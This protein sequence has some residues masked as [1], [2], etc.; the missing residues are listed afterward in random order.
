MA[1][2]VYL[3]NEGSKEDRDLLG[4]KGA[5]LCEMTNLGLP[6]P[7]GFIITTSTCREFFQAGNRLPNLLEQEYRVAL[8]LIEKKMGTRFGDPDNPLLFSVRSGAP[9]SMPG[10][11][12]TILNL[13]MN[14]EITEGLARKTSNPRFA[15]DSYRRFI[16]MFADVVLDIDGRLFEGEITRYKDAHSKPLDTDMTAEDWQAVIETFKSMA[17]FPQDPFEQ[18]KL[19]VQ[20]VFLSW[21][22][23]RAIVYREMNNIP[24]SLGTAVNVQA[25]VFGNYGEDSGSGVAFTRNPSTGENEFFGE[26]LF[27]AAGEDVVA[28]VRTPEPVEALRKRLTGV[29]DELYETQDLLEKHYRDMQDIEFTVQ[30]GRFYMLQTRSGKRTGRASIKIA[31]DMVDEQLITRKEALLR[32]SPEHVEA[33]LHPMVDPDSKENIIATGLPA[34]PGGATGR[35]VFSADEA[36]ETAKDGTQVI[37]VR[38]ETTPEDIHGMKVAEGILTELGGMTS[39]AAVV[40]RGMGVCAI[41]G[42]GSLTI[43]YDA[44][45]ATTREGVTVSRGDIITLD[46]NSAEVMLGDIPKTEARDSDDFQLLLN[47]A[48][49][50]RRL[51]VRANAETPEDAK[52]ARELGAEGVG[53]C[54]TEHMFFEESRVALMRGMILADDAEERQTYLDSILEFHQADMLSLFQIMDG[55][56]VTIRLLDPPLHEFLPHLGADV[57]HLAEQ[58]GKSASS[59]AEAVDHLREVNP[60]LGLRGCRLSIVMPEV[61][62]MQVNAIIG[63]AAQAIEMGLNPAPEIMIPLVINV[64]EVRLISEI[65]D[66]GVHAALKDRSVSVRYKIGTMM[67]TPRACLGADRLAPAVEFM[68][69]GTNDLTQMTYGFSRDDSGKFVPQY[70]D[71]KIIES[72]PFVSLDQRAV[73]RLMELAVKESRARK[74]GIKYGICGE[75]GGDPRSIQFCHDLGLDYVSCSPY[76]IP[77]ARIAAAQAA[78]RDSI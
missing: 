43:D 25:M 72:D 34:S 49:R 7:F 65:I 54:R 32:V 59:I 74:S 57:E 51:K 11:M 3:F 33:F 2:R 21:H 22:T 29:Y 41:T 26:F 64:R 52:K 67:E 44:G 36:V 70:L 16:Q 77:V 1:K 30:E 35:V 78:V 61:T 24:E 23:P 58:I 76:R 68:S 31:V 20:A 71:K 9:V 45:T 38:R 10:M 8:D 14:D 37:L 19:A 12:N 63:A 56:P 66:R 50:Y 6:V 69:F 55:L 18:L 75:H 13:G 48:D 17:D 40:A 27:N 4:G 62:E 15:Y 42:C 28:G 39:H 47:W 5:N 46:G 73:G 60:M 53:L